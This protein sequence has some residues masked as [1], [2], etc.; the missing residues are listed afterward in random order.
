MAHRATIIGASIGGLLTAT[1]L[2]D[3]FDDIVIV[4]SDQLP[5]QP[6]HRAGV[7]QGNQVHALLAIGV[8]AMEQLLPGIVDELVAAGGVKMDAGCEGA[9]YEAEGWAGR[10]TSEARV[11][12]MRRTHLEHVIRRRVLAL[13]KVTLHAAEVTGLRAS[14]DGRR[15]GT[16]PPPTRERSP[17]PTT[18]EHDG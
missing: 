3:A 15:V 17:Q 5:E 4:E 12:S 13:P 9:I 10:V 7:P 1:A 16:G 2:H 11:V 6:A 8:R 14:V 18:G